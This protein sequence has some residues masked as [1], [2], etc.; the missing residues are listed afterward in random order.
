MY[1]VL[2]LLLAFPSIYGQGMMDRIRTEYQDFNYNKVIELTREALQNRNTSPVEDVKEILLM[3]A[4][5]YYSLNNLTDA[6]AS[7]Q[8]LLQIDYN[9]S[10]DPVLTSPKII[11]FF[12]QIKSSS[13]KSKPLAVEKP[14]HVDTVKVFFERHPG[15]PGA[16]VRS[17]VLPGWGQCYLD[18][19]TKSKILTVLGL[20]T[21]AVAVYSIVD[22]HRKENDYLAEYNVAN[23]EN[24]YQRYNNAYKLRNALLFTYATLWLATQVDLLFS[25]SK[26]S[27]QVKS[28]SITPLISIDHSFLV[29]L[30]FYLH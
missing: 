23:L 8:D 5:A 10:L 24:K 26:D 7:F 15:L 29:S 3:Q 4:I 30:R 1:A 27:A 11:Q 22:C 9:Y 25:D 13:P 16:V 19:S 20:T 17:F 28:S 12:N 2:I 14:A 21:S 6:A 18:H